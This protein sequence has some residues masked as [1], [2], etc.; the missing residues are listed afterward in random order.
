MSAEKDLRT[1]VNFL[2]F[3]VGWS[4]GL[5]ISALF[6]PRSGE[7]TR[8]TLVLKANE[9]KGRAAAAV[10]NGKN[11]VSDKKDQLAAAVEA[12]REV[13]KQ[14]VAKAKATGTETQG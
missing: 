14:E 10:E 13:Y 1:G 4:V 3:V 7:Q 6:A 9:L 12:G 11:M 8:A 2:Y 5:S